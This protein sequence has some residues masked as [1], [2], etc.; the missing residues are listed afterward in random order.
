MG[1]A[2]ARACRRA[3][4]HVSVVYGKI[5]T[6]LPENLA[7][8]EQAISAQAMHD[9]VFRQLKLGQDIF[10]AVSA[11]ADYRVANASAHKIKKVSGSVPILEL[12]ENP[13]I[14]RDVAALPHAP[15]CVGFAAES[16]DVLAH[17]QEKRLKKNVPMLIANAVSDA[18]GKSTNKIII[19]DEIGITQ[20]PQMSKDEAAQI[21]VERIAQ[22]LPCTFQAA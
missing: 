1:V 17:A 13:D 22:N 20:L 3:G 9:A 5:S 15:F 18:M 8:T 16:N 10:I 19:L 12:T 4:A 14:L 2:L 21:I 7:Y 6:T 11:V